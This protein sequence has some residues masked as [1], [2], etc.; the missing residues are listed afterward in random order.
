MLLASPSDDG[1]KPTPDYLPAS[2][3]FILVV[4][5]DCSP[6]SLL[7]TLFWPP[8]VLDTELLPETIEA[9]CFE[10]VA[11]LVVDSCLEFFFDLA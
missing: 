5:E 3:T 9:L 7:E 2:K 4:L 8:D 1:L 11:L 10:A 6:L